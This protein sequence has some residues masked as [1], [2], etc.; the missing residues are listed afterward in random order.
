MKRFIAIALVLVC[1]FATYSVACAEESDSSGSEFES[2]LLQKGSLIQKS[3]TEYGKVIESSLEGGCSKGMSLGIMLQTAVVTDIETGYKY[4]AIR[5]EHECLDSHLNRNT[6]V[7]VLDDDEISS[8]I[9]T[10]NYIKEHVGDL[11]DYSEITYTSN[12]DIKIGVA[13][14]DEGSFLFVDFASRD[15]VYADVSTIDT[16]IEGFKGAQE[17]LDNL[18]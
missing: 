15:T 7:G 9:T 5:M 10:L 14:D 16:I 11:K 1:I 2:V 8:V 6:V 18:K 3:F 17:A 12:G 13:T 4:Y